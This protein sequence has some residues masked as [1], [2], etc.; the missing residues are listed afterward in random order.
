MCSC[1]VMGAVR[2]SVTLAMLCAFSPMAWGSPCSQVR[3]QAAPPHNGDSQELMPSAHPCASWISHE[4]E[5]VALLLS[6]STFNPA[7][8]LGCSH[9]MVNAVMESGA[10]ADAPTMDGAKWQGQYLPLGPKPSALEPPWGSSP[11]F[12]PFEGP[13]VS[14]STH[15][16]KYHGHTDQG[17]WAL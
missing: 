13:R 17:A 5:A 12:C 11:L 4:G 2:P 6:T 10:H 9:P 1:P 7:A 14:E 3:P 15:I 8:T 16:W